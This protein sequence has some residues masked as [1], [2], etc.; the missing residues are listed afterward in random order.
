MVL[1][2]HFIVVSSLVAV[3]TGAASAA[4]V[5]DGNLSDWGVSI[6][7]NNVHNYS[8]FGPSIG[9]LSSFEEDQND[10]AGLSATLGPNLGG[11]DYDAELMAV[12][13][14]N[15]TLYIA[16]STGQRPDNGFTYF[17]PG[18][19]RIETSGGTYWLEVG[20]GQGG[21]VG[22]LITAGAVGSTYTLKSNGETQSYANAAALQ[23]AGSV[24]TGVTSILDP[25]AP[26]GPTQ[27][28]INGGSTSVG[29][30]SYAYTR[31]SQTTQHA[32]I[33]AG[34]NIAMFNGET[35]ESIHWR[36]GCGNDEVDVCVNLVPEPATMSLLVGGLALLRNRRKRA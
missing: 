12:A 36:P 35:I 20:G 18:D 34:L 29:T 19:I 4:I 15:Y 10:A 5:V 23:T 9:L 7:D 24:W 25:I 14:D 13:Y 16:I 32:F 26:Q 31:N 1:R 28:A 30:A 27:F 17:G 22:T 3:L 11:Q 8:L 21:G 6:A 33:E 2:A